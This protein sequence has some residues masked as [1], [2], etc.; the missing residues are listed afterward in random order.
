MPTNT[1]K[2]YVACIPV[3]V[4]RELVEDS[5]VGGDKC[6][7]WSERIQSSDSRCFR[8]RELFWARIFLPSEV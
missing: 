8:R 5:H 4:R 6:M 7:L 1:Y 3:K 2:E